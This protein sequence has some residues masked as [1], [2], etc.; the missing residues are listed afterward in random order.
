MSP[1]KSDPHSNPFL[2]TFSGIDGAGKTTQ[3]KWLASCLE[4]RQLR[5]LQLSFWDHVAVWPGLRSGLG[6]RA[7]GIYCPARAEESFTV[8]NHK[9]VRRWYLTAV[10]SCLYMLDVLRLRYLLAR[11]NLRNCDVIIFDRY[12]YDQLA[13]IYSQSVVTR[14]Y[15]QVL[16]KQ[17]PSPD[18]AFILDTSPAE[19]FRRKPEYPL[20]FMYKN[21]RAFLW[22]RE[23]CPKLITIPGDTVEEATSEIHTHLRRSRLGHVS[24]VDD[25]QT[26]EEGAV[27]QSVNSC[28][29]QNQPT[30]S[31]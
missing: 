10:R 8:K 5:V 18:L 7:V 29:V 1:E 31:V 19:A 23:F 16:I 26:C 2:I 28:R 17:T 27:M 30:E 6:Q 11:H 13:N 15:I 4:K 9:H 14:T 3:I 25:S 20:E 12:V 24:D 21:R 22:L